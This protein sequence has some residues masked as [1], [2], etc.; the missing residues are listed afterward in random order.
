MWVYISAMPNTG[1]FW[2]FGAFCEDMTTS[3]LP[4]LIEEFR[5]AT[6]H[7][8]AQKVK[9]ELHGGFRRGSE[10]VPESQGLPKMQLE[11]FSLL[12]VLGKG[13]FGKVS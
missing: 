6:L 4:Q 8:R 7:E 12:V 2:C 5:K 3:C 13:S 10:M 9:E 11:D 1:V